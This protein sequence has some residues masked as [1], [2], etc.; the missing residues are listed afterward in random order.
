MG[1]SR[2]IARAIPMRCRSPPDSV[3]PRSPT[4]VSY[5]SGRRTMKSCA[6][7]RRAASTISFSDAEGRPYAMFSRT[8]ARKSTVS[9]STNP[10][11][12]RIPCSL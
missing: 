12:S 6:F 5:P 8:V 7:A 10:I 2:T 4:R 1:E 11:W 3:C 9:W